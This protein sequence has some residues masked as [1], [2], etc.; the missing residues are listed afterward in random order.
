MPSETRNRKDR[1]QLVHRDRLDE[2]PEGREIESLNTTIA[3]LE[4]EVED[5][6]GKLASAMGGKGGKGASAEVKA[7][8][9]NIDGLNKKLKKVTAQLDWDSRLVE[10]TRELATVR[11]QV[12]QLQAQLKAKCEE[13]DVFETRV[14]Q[15]EQGPAS[16]ADLKREKEKKESNEKI[17]KMEEKMIR[18]EADKI[19]LAGQLRAAK[20]KQENLESLKAT[21]ERDH[22]RLH[23]EVK[24]SEALAEHAEKALSDAKSMSK[25]YEGGC[26]LQEKKLLLEN[27]DQLKQLAQEHE[28]RADALAS[29]KNISMVKPDSVSQ[30]T[31]YLDLTN[32][33]LSEDNVSTLLSEGPDWPPQSEANE[34]KKEAQEK[35]AK[36]E[37]EVIKQRRRAEAAEKEKE[38]SGGQVSGNGRS[39]ASSRS[40]SRTGRK[41]RLEE[42]LEDVRRERDRA[43]ERLQE[44]I[45]QLEQRLSSFE[46]KAQVDIDRLGKSVSALNDQIAELRDENTALLLK[47][48]G[49]E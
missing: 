49:V 34:E 14:K 48:V 10:A 47:L 26:T 7:L 21:L 24:D 45:S 22:R 27:I 31:R 5:L 29:G 33:R 2:R 44:T 11:T 20:A 43:K 16:T 36:L 25:E 12:S 28:Q 19:N 40:S 41:V 38:R 32:L 39:R 9:K 17:V 3:A 4:K 35:I 37:V 6:K 23:D 8:Q 1:A 15:L 13:S 18:L 42:E 46:A 30:V